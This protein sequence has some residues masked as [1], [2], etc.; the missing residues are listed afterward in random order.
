MINL[1]MSYSKESL[2][3]VDVLPCPF[4]GS[5]DNLKITSDITF[6]KLY[7]ENGDATIVLTCT[8]CNLDMYEHSYHK[9]DYEQKAMILI[10][11]WNRRN[12]RE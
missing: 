11:K 9:N 8:K 4:C 3:S 5:T 2:E 7:S 1:K 10:E 12:G 6:Y